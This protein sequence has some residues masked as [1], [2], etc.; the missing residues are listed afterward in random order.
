MKIRLAL[1]TAAIALMTASAAQAGTITFNTDN[2]DPAPRAA[3][4]ALIEQFQADNPDITVEMNVFDREAYKTAIRNW[5][6]SDSPPDVVTWYA[7]ERMNTFAE[8]GLFSDVTDVWQDNDLF[9]LM[10][11]S[12]S[13][14]AYDG[15]QYGVP[16]TYYQWGV[17]YRTDIFEDN[18]IEVPETFDDLIAACVTLREADIAPVAIGTRYLWTAAGWFDYLN[19]RTNGLDYHMGLMAGEIPYTDDGVRETFANWQ[20]LLDAN[21][22]IDNHA[23][24]SWQEAVPFVVQGE[25]AMYLIGNF[26]TPFFPQDDIE[27][28][29]FFQFPVINPDIGMYEDAPID[30]FHIPTNASN[31]EDARR[32]LAYLAEAGVQTQINEALLQLPPNS[33]SVVLDDPFLESGFAMLSA[34]D[35][36]AQFYDRDTDPEMARTGMEGFQEFMVNPDRLDGI[37]ERLDRTRQR[38]FR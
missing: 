28:Y 15:V 13:A 30:T 27:N 35:G 33:D 21:C 23:A 16:F 38:I 14:L 10:S 31:P 11:S 36:I 24:Y 20:R 1:A 22:Y 34:A 4:E 18:G 29:G 6:A 32:F 12:A 7:G 2:A 37:L 8:L 19:L 3:M 17:Y 5:L 25:A 26:I 9:D